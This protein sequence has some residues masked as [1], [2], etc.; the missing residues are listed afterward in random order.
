MFP[1]AGAVRSAWSS[2]YLQR[3]GYHFSLCAD[4][5]Q[6]IVTEDMESTAVDYVDDLDDL[7]RDL[8][9]V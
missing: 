5:A 3:V 1:G 8:C 9:E 6:D 2:T 4:P 7:G